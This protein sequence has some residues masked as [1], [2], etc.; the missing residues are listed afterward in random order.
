MAMGVAADARIYKSFGLRVAVDYLSVF[1]GDKTVLEVG[2]KR[3][4][5][6]ED[7]QSFQKV[8]LDG[9]VQQNFRVAVGPTWA[10]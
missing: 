7:K 1:A 8:T 10:W 9:G 3:R 4:L 5:L 6:N 2:D